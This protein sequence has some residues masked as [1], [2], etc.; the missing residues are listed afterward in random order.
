MYKN[1][2]ITFVAFASLD[3]RLSAERIEAQAFASKYYDEIKIFDSDDF[4]NQMKETYKNLKIS[5]KKKRVWL[6][7]LEANYTIKGNERN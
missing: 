6:L 7:V 3:L 2:K 4:D 1:R 5:Q